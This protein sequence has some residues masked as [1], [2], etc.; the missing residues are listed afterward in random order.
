[1]VKNFAKPDANQSSISTDRAPGLRLLRAAR[2]LVL[3]A[4]AILALAVSPTALF[5]TPPAGRHIV[6]VESKDAAGKIDR[7]RVIRIE[8]QVRS[9]LHIDEST[10]PEIVLIHVTEDEAQAAG[11]PAG[12]MVMVERSFLNLE[13]KDDAVP[14]R[15][16]VWVVG[17][18]D[19]PKMVG[20]VAHVLRLHLKLQLSDGDLL[21]AEKRILQRLNATVD[22]NSFVKRRQ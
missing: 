19:D 22:V 1:M 9:E 4:I 13:S 17:K 12:M 2:Q 11:V 7:Q 5:G 15:F 6:I 18:P 3:S 20:A 21:L 16:L 8:E 14:A 10:V